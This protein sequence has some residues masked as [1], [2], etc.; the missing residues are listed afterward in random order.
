ME[1]NG[2]MN[3]P[4]DAWREALIDNLLRSIRFRCSAY[5]RPELRAPWGFSIHDRGPTFHIVSEGKCWIEV[6]GVSKPVQLSAGDFVV[7]PR[8]DLHVI[9]DSPT[10]QVVDFF[11]FLKGRV[12]DKQ[13][14]F[15]AGG[16]GSVTRLVCGE[17]QPENGATDPLLAVLPPLIHVNGRGGDVAPGLRVTVNQ[18]FE[19]LG[20]GRSGSAAVVTRL[21]DILFMQA[22]RAY[23]D[24]NIDIVGSGWLAALRDQQIGR[25]LVLLHDKPHQPWA[26]AELADRVALSRSAFAAKFTQLVGEPPLRYLTRLRLNAATAR[27]RSGNDKLSVIADAA[28]YESAPAFAKAFKRQFGVTP[29]EYRRSR[30]K[31]GSV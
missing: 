14:A 10:T 7:I 29:G 4:T 22:I 15:S 23:L 18:V 19:E 2:A 8:S 26:V 11:D 5:Y 6:K 17:M 28:G 20:S 12:P 25:A 21:A 16:A 3:I 31:D 1:G 13:G 24:E 27:L 30:Q 9:R